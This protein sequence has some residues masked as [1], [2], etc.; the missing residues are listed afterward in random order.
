M[1]KHNSNNG[2]VVKNSPA[3]APAE[4]VKPPVGPT[5]AALLAS[6]GGLETAAEAVATPT[7]PAVATPAPAP[8]ANP[9]AA[10][11][12]GLTG[13]A[14]ATKE[15]KPKRTLADMLAAVKA[16][17]GK[18]EYPV[19]LSS[20][21]VFSAAAVCRWLGAWGYPTGKVNAKGEAV[22]LRVSVRD[23]ALC[24]AYLATLPGNDKLSQLSE[25]TVKTQH[26]R[27]RSGDG[28]T[29]VLTEDETTEVLAG[30]LNNQ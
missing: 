26:N 15:K 7:A 28:E 25:S 27:G 29:P 20:G 10:K 9:L 12:A 1:A 2:N 19:T 30:W 5:A 3:P 17:G 21:R 22:L 16:G 24:L 18:N 6:V 11:L 8:A 13:T 14:D 4:A 23:A